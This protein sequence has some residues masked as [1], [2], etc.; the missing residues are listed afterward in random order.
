LSVALSTDQSSAKR[1]LGTTGVCEAATNRWN[2]SFGV[3]LDGMTII[4]IAI[5]QQNKSHDVF[6]RATAP[7]G[8]PS[9]TTKSLGYLAVLHGWPTSLPQ[10]LRCCRFS[11]CPPRGRPGKPMDGLVCTAWVGQTM[12]H[13][14]H[15]R[16]VVDDR[17]G[18]DVSLPLSCD[19]GQARV[20]VWTGLRLS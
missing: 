20:P 4:L 3:V 18:Y 1:E 15:V 12:P 19:G 8:R 16:I 5:Y 17:G 14:T 2:A 11:N 7:H 9:L 6:P 10:T 13:H